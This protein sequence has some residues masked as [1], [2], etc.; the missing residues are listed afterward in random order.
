MGEQ[1]RQ[2]ES[3]GI[4][5]LHIDVMDGHFVPNLSMGPPVAASVRKAFT[6]MFLDAHL[7]VSDPGFFVEPF[8][9]AGCDLVNFQIETT[10][11]PIELARRI[12][13]YSVRVGVTLNPDTPADAIWPLL[14][15]PIAD[16]GVDLV[17]VM[18][19]HPGFGGQKFID[20]VLPK[21]EAIRRRLA[22]GQ[23]LEID[24]GIDTTT[25]SRAVSAGANVLV[26]GTSVFGKPDPAQAVR[27]LIAAAGGRK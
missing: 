13:G 25:A 21:V 19:V 18:S 26:A 9:A 22:P 1:I 11:K 20:A 16:G 15:R 14:D 3:A 27:D 2:V 24:G 5:W 23:Y 12:R 17:L 10:D 4:R 6:G 8:V 7:M